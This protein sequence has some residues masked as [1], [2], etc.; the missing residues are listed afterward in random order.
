MRIIHLQMG[1]LSPTAA[2]PQP[3][4][5]LVCSRGRPCGS[6]ICKWECCLPLLCPGRRIASCELS[7]ALVRASCEAIYQLKKSV[8]RHFLFLAQPKAQLRDACY[9]AG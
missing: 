2:A 7:Q 6:L 3:P 8:R 5:G 4:R 9:G 1:V